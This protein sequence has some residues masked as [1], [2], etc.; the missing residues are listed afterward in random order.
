MGL[1]Y[2]VAH[3]SGI[4]LVLEATITALGRTLIGFI[5]PLEF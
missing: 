4:K 2:R 1:K 3:L 5:G